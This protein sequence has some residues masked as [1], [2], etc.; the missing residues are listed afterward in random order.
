M[1]T[2]ND[3]FNVEFTKIEKAPGVEW[4]GRNKLYNFGIS[5]AETTTEQ[6]RETWGAFR[7]ARIP[8]MYGDV[9]M[10][11]MVDFFGKINAI[12]KNGGLHLLDGAILEV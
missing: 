3:P 4:Q 12:A 11:R 6:D 2:I 7:Y 8:G 1:A 10:L 5:I 9:S